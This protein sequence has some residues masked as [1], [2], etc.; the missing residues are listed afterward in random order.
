V[1]GL[2]IGIRLD[3]RCP[4]GDRERARKLQAGLLDLA[5]AA[6]AAGLDLLWLAESP[7][8]PDALVPAVFPVCAALAARTERLRIATGLL[9]LPLHHPLR[10]AEDAATVDG[11]SQGRFELGVGLGAE[12]GAFAG[13]GLLTEERAGRFEEAVDLIRRAWGPAPVRFQGRHFQCEGLEVMPK[14]LQAGGPPIWLGARAESGKR[15]AARLGAGL[16][17]DGDQSPE[18]YLEDWSETAREAR[19]AFVLPAGLDADESLARARRRIDEVD[20]RARVDLAFDW[21]LTEEA[22][23]AAALSEFTARLRAGLP[24]AGA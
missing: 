2:R 5:E 1:P 17:L 3:P 9:P 7:A 20:G 23:G 19:I 4:A 12:P 24:V 6:E 21:P 16:V 14:P 15:R 10:V 22:A 13:F 11:I 8:D 18:P